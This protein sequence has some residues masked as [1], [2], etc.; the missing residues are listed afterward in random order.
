MAESPALWLQAPMIRITPDE[1]KFD[2]T[3]E[4]A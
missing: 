2:M 3:F 1:V 4:A